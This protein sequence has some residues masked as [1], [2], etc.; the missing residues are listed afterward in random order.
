VNNL[1]SDHA[2]EFEGYIKKWQDLLNL[3]DWRIERGSKAAEKGTMAEVETT[4]SQRLAVYRLGKSFGTTAVTPHSLESTALHELLHV[5]L[6]DL[7]YSTKAT[8]DSAEHRVVNTL[9][10]L[11]VPKP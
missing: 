7:T 8:A 10:R 2:S 6:K 4:Y 1:T 11:L 9:E 3:N 5:L